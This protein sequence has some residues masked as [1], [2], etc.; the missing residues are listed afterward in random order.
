M[1]I[2]KSL[3]EAPKGLESIDDSEPDIQIEIEDPE[4]VTLSIGEIGR[5]H[6]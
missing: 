6:V 2:E 1:A 3:Y 5:A 4:D